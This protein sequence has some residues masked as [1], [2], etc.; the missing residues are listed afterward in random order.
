MSVRFK[1]KF[2]GATRCELVHEQ[3]GAVINTVAPRDNG[4]DGSA[5]SPTDMFASSLGSCMMTIF[6]MAASREGLSCEG[7]WFEVEKHMNAEPR[8]IGKLD[9]FLHLPATLSQLARPKL[10]RAA[11]ACPVSQSLH[12]E[13]LLNIRFLYD[14]SS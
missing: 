1:G 6:S 4:G 8:R 14:V 13:V 11:L 7:A 2:L 5:F 12:P 9:V 3:S 10:E